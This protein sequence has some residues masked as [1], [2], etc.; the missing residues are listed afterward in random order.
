MRV[1][2]AGATGAIGR[3]L[4]PLLVAEGHDVVAMTRS[5]EKVDGLRSMGAVPV[6]ADALDRAAVREAVTDARPDVVVHELSALS[7]T[8]GLRRFD[9][10]FGPTNELR[11]KGTDYLLEAAVAGGARRFVAQSYAGWPCARDGRPAKTED[12]PLDPR[13]PRQMQRSL[14]ALRHLEEAVLGAREVEGLV[15]RYGAFYGAGTSIAEDG[16]LVDLIRRRRFPIVGSG[17]GVWSFVHVDDAATATA[18]AVDRGQPGIY[19]IVDDEPAPVRVWLPELA[20]VVG[21]PPPRRVP[22]WVAR[23]A[24]GQVGVS[25]MTQVRGASNAKAKRALGWSPEH[26]SWRSG[27]RTGLRERAPTGR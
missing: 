12:E 25:L 4:V 5:P 10:E 15:L 21:A 6:V 22:T 27:F 11:T 20:A 23:L 8:G 18:L 16:D 13:P 19:N 14:A 3:R 17:S 24:A 1:F 9:R 2:V 7:T 26:G